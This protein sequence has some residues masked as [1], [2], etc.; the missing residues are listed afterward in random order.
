MDD[1]RSCLSIFISISIYPTIYVYQVSIHLST[2]IYNCLS[3]YLYIHL[4][5]FVFFSLRVSTI[6]TKTN[7]KCTLQCAE[8]QKDPTDLWNCLW[9]SRSFSLLE[10][11]MKNSPHSWEI[12]SKSTRKRHTSSSA[13]WNRTKGKT[14]RAVRKEEH[15]HSELR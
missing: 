6:K 3:T 5:I 1:Y 15:R 11:A 8:L 9:L 7:W 13:I 14:W 4:S 10:A 12:G 2:Y